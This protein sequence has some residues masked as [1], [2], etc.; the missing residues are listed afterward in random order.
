MVFGLLIVACIWGY[1]NLTGRKAHK[2]Q[3]NVPVQTDPG[4][5]VPGPADVDR[6]AE[7]PKNDRVSADVA[8]S[9]DAKPWGRNPF[10]RRAPQVKAPTVTGEQREQLEFQLSGILYRETGAQAFIN[11][12]VVAVGDTIL[13]YRVTA[14]TPDYVAVD[15]GATRRTLRVKKESS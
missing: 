12:R 3:E 1:A 6:G 7:I 4:I 9:Y 13:G 11:G 5:D 2:T 10:Y 15:N 14:I 8:A